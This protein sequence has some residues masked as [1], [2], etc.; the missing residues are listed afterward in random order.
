MEFMSAGVP[1][2]ASSTKIDRY[3]FDDSVVRFFES[4]NADALAEAMLEVLCGRTAR[5][6]MVANALDYAARNSWES[7]KRV[8]LDLVDSLI[9]GKPVV[10]EHVDPFEKQRIAS[11]LPVS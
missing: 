4:G 11:A 1:V 8:Y 2:V 5:E 10:P 6:R 9:E 7:R 3:Y